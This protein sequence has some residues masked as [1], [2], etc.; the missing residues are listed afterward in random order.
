MR[1]TIHHYAVL[2]STNDEAKRLLKAGAGEGTVIHAQCQ[3]AG[4]GRHGRS[5]VSKP[6][7]LFCSLILTPQC[8]LNH[9]GQLS[10]VMAV[11]AGQTI[12][13]YLLDP[14][15][16]SY[17]W[18]NDLLLEGKKLAGILI[19]AESEGREQEDG[20]RSVCIVGI[21]VNLRDCPDPHPYPVTALKNYTTGNIG[22]EAI[23][24]E[25]L[26]QTQYY[27]QIWQH[28]GFDPIRE[29]WLHRAYGLGQ[30]KTL[31]VGEKEIQGRFVGL[32]PTGALLLQKED[33]EISNLVSAEIL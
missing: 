14:S 25:L 22:Q 1:F 12:T 4:R 29:A 10:F 21:G 26:N 7:N 19:E 3:T 32:S 33:G 24:N 15:I 27:Y 5:W 17:K 6:G 13:P 8:P 30:E 11:A 18:P 2:G 31:K 16:L 28:K 23:L 20:G 9:L